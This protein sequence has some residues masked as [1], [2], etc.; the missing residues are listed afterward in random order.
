[1][2]KAE[3]LTK[4]FGKVK[5]LRGITFELKHSEVLAILGP[6]GSGKTTLLRLLA[7]L[8]QPDKG[9][10]FIDG[11]KASTNKYVL[12]PYKRKLSMI[13]QDL[14]LWPHMSVTQHVMF[15]FDSKASKE[16]VKSEVTKILTSIGLSDYTKRYPKELSGGQKQRLAIARAIASRPKYLMMDEPFSNLDPISKDEL[17]DLVVRLKNSRNVGI[18]CVSHDLDVLE[19]ADRVAIINAGTIEQIGNKEQVYR[20]PK[21]I[22]VKRFLRIK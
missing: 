15:A 14:A 8:E 13:F 22:F 5:A 4:S 21:D 12:P 19:I 20:E 16:K 18:A 1:M 3:N 11:I 10:V 9:A 6:S 2:I 17:Q 7:G